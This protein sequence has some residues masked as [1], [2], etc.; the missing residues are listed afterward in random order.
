MYL[1]DYKFLKK[2]NPSK[3]EKLLSTLQDDWKETTK[4]KIIPN[5]TYIIQPV[6]SLKPW[7]I[8]WNQCVSSPSFFVRLFMTRFEINL[9]TGGKLKYRPSKRNNEQITPLFFMHNQHLSQNLR[10]TIL[11]IKKTTQ[12]LR[13]STSRHDLR[14]FCH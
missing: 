4:Y 3:K 8:V 1:F 14:I 6:K 7:I 9:E 12:I 5:F 2:S 11:P 10:L 13:R